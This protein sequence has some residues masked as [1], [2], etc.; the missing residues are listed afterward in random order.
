MLFF[1]FGLC[2]F[3][4]AIPENFVENSEIL[5]LVTKIKLGYI[6]SHCC[7]STAFW[8]SDSAICVSAANTTNL[9]FFGDNL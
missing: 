7:G 3:F 2:F 9:T 5:V 6:Y 1:S 8:L 4:V